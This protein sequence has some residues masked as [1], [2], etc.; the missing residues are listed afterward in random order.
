[1]QNLCHLQTCSTKNRC[2]KKVHYSDN[3]NFIKALKRR[4]DLSNQTP[5]IG[6]AHSLAHNNNLTSHLVSGSFDELYSVN[7]AQT[8]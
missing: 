4:F 7:G 3:V 2:P 1:M 6:L 8:N 5:I